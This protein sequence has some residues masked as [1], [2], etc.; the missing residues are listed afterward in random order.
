MPLYLTIGS[1]LAIYAVLVGGLYVFQRQLLYFPDRTRPTLGPL[2]VLGVQ[3][4]KLQTADGLSLLSWYLP[5]RN[6]HPVIAY[7]HG[8][9]GHIGYRT[10]RLRQ[11]AEHGYGV[12]MLEYRGYGGNPGTPTEIGLYADAAAALNFLDQQG[13]RPGRVVLY[14]ESL[15]SGVAVRLAAQRDIAA[16]ILEAPF[17]SVAEVAQHH[18]SFFVPAAMLVRDRFDSRSLIGEVKVPIL[19]LHGERDRIVPMRFGRA[20]FDAAPE[21]KEFWT[22]AEAGH[23][24]L[25]RFGALEAVRNFIDR[26]VGQKGMGFGGTVEC[27]TR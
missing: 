27:P 12:L 13:I 7:F 17:T 4:V 14:G 19:V 15:G 25:A 16:L 9:G 26:W 8:N 11:F 6:S 1:A 24:G 10:G 20:L 18:Y 2:A 3:E 21:P 22:A 23:E 5:P